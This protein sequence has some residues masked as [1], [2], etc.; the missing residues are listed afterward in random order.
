MILPPP[1]WSGFM[2][3]VHSRTSAYSTS[4]VLPLPLVTMDPTKLSTMCTCIL[5]AAEQRKQIVDSIASLSRLTF[6][7]QRQERWFWLRGNLLSF[8]ASA[9]G[10]EVFITGF[11]QGFDL[12]PEMVPMPLAYMH[13]HSLFER[14][15]IMQRT[16]LF[17]WHVMNGR[18]CAK[19]TRVYLL[20]EREHWQHYYCSR[21]LQSINA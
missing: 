4:A 2:S 5:L 13:V 20:S 17:T 10:S 21:P 14:D 3:K 6:P 12:W 15:I 16:V 8:P 9:F 11:Y 7:L 19:G 1:C 18:A